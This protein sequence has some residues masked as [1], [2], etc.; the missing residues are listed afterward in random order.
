MVSQQF[1][2]DD[3]LFRVC[4]KTVEWFSMLLVA[5]YWVLLFTGTRWGDK[6]HFACLFDVSVPVMMVVGICALLTWRRYPKHALLLIG[7]VLAWGIWAALPR[8]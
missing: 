2:G 4:F 3:R 7:V 5:L 8:L 1:Q 6:F